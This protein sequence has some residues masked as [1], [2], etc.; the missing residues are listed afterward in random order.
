MNKIVIGA[1]VIFVSLSAMAQE[2]EAVEQAQVAEAMSELVVV[3]TSMLML[4]EGD[5]YHTEF[6]TLMTTQFSEILITNE[7]AKDLSLVQT[8]HFY[9]SAEPN[10][11]TLNQVVS[12]I[13]DADSPT[14]FSVSL[15]REYNRNNG[16]YQF[17]A[18]V[19]EYQDLVNK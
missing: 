16:G 13:I 9:L 4:E 3:E 7:Q 5:Q 14:Y 6:M 2:N 15:F 8:K 1:V 10:I 11:T 17:G 19:T 18:K 12:D